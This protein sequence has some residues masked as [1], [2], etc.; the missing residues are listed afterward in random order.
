MEIAKECVR[1]QKLSRLSGVL[2]TVKGFSMIATSMTRILQKEVKFEWND[3]C[4]QIFEKLKSLLTEAPVLVQPK[5]GKKF[6]VYNYASLNGLG[7]VLIQEGKVIAYA[8]RQLKPHDKNY[9]T[10]DLELAATVLALKI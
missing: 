3:K 9:L 8:S 7:C 2:Q 10:H 6:M 5:L 4:Q 1:D